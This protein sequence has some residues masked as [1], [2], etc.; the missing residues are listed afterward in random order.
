MQTL[1]FT[2][3]YHLITDQIIGDGIELPF[4]IKITNDNLVKEKLIWEG[5]KV[6]MGSLEY[7]YLFTCP[8]FYKVIDVVATDEN[9]DQILSD[10]LGDCNTLL[11]DLWQIKDNAV[12]HQMGYLYYPFRRQSELLINIPYSDLASGFTHSNLMST[13]FSNCLGKKEPVHFT[14][15][16]LKEL[17]RF[18]DDRISIPISESSQRK[19]LIGTS[20]QRITRAGLFIQS[21][22]T[23]YDIALKI[24]HYCT[25]LECLFTTDNKELSHK[26]SERASLLIG[27]NL[28]ERKSI[29]KQIKEI[30]ELR[31]SVLHGSTLGKKSRNRLE[32]IS[33]NA[34]SILRRIYRK[35]NATKDLDKFYRDPPPKNE[36]DPQ[37]LDDY[38]LDRILNE[39][40]MNSD[41]FEIGDILEATHRDLT[42]G[43]HYII[44]YEG[45]SKNDFC[46]GMITHSNDANNV[47]M[48]KG[49]FIEKD[50][51]GVNYK[52]VFD[53][54]YLVKGKFLKSEVWGP[55]TKVGCLTED[56][57]GFLKA[58]IGGLSS[59]SFGEYFYRTKILK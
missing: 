48:D 57:I 46:G 7:D 47:K 19:T 12:D 11:Y 58:T 17:I 41:N 10:F 24:S 55:F 18:N 16:E 39:P 53:E 59:E 9:K 6:P 15:E 49:H 3:V 2:S 32:E 45:H 54:T 42:K 5:L 22:R 23:N 34:D 35:I 31:S 28:E 29:Y 43:R 50:E 40:Q 44:Y 13:S 1:L 8:I 38:F 33:Q 27:N 36:G 21:A 20:D 37:T 14:N 51:K 30:Y 4:G 56:G 25:A 52:I 26:V